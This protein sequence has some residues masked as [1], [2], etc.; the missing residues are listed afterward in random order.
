MQT[1]SKQK[2]IARSNILAGHRRAP[3]TASRQHRPPPA[4]PIPTEAQPAGT[5]CCPWRGRCSNADLLAVGRTSQLNRLTAK[6]LSHPSSTMKGNES[7]GNVTSLCYCFQKVFLLFHKGVR[8]FDPTGL[9]GTINGC[10]EAGSWELGEWRAECTVRI[11]C[12]AH[13]THTRTQGT[14]FGVPLLPGRWLLRV[15]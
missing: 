10:G 8:N 1:N 5:T 12:P 13:Y 3:N 7:S 14:D 2:H 11:L 4:T 6:D 15:T 9:S